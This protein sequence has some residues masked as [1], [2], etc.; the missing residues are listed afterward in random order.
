MKIYKGDLPL[1]I[2]YEEKIEFDTVTN[3][4]EPTQLS[5]LKGF[6]VEYSE[7]RDV[8]YLFPRTKAGVNT[9]RWISIERKDIQKVINSLE[10]ILKYY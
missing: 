5:T 7:K 8:V 2:T 6:D 9:R 4:S 1:N 10:E 3:F